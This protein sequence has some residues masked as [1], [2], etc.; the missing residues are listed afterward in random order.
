MNCFMEF[1]FKPR[2]CLDFFGPLGEKIF[3]C[4]GEVKKPNVATDFGPVEWLPLRLEIRVKELL[5]E[6]KIGSTFTLVLAYE[7]METFILTGCSIS[8]IVCV[9]ESVGI[10]ITF[11]KVVN[12]KHILKEEE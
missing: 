12:K 2:I 7:D 8:D 3:A 1:W 9:E 4:H 10:N 11:N 5:P 6:F